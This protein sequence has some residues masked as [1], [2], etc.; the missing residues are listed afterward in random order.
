MENRLMLVEQEIRIKAYEI[1]AMGVVSNIEYV[2]Y[3]ED[4]RH[5]FLDHYYP[6][7]EMMESH[8]SPVLMNT[9]I[10]YHRPLTIHSKPVGRCWVTKMK[11]AKWELRFEIESEEGLHCEGIQKGGF[12]D[13]QARRPIRCP[14]KLLDQYLAAVDAAAGVQ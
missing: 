3:F 7:D 8:I 2:K 10:H 14:A 1:D 5:V 4:L 13:V 12:F 11:Q 6:F 9:D